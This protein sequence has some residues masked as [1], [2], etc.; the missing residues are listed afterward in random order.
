[1]NEFQEGE[2]NKIYIKLLLSNRMPNRNQ[3]TN[4]VGHS[5]LLIGMAI[6]YELLSKK[7]TIDRQMNIKHFFAKNPFQPFSKKTYG[8]P[9]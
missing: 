9:L 6:I 7:S 1:M 5:A 8:K 3:S 4:R 2:A